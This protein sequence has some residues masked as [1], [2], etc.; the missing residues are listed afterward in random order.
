MRA[1]GAFPV[2]AC[3]LL[4]IISSLFI[5]LISSRSVSRSCYDMASMCLSVIS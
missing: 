4:I 5:R 3:I 2:A 1:E